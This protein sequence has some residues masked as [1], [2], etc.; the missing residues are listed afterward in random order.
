MQGLYLV[1]TYESRSLLCDPPLYEVHSCIRYF[2]ELPVRFF[3]IFLKQTVIFINQI[4]DIMQVM[5]HFNKETGILLL[6]LECFNAIYCWCCK[7]VFTRIQQF[8]YFSLIKN[9]AFFSVF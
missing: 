3:N 9:I 8:I 7:A 1:N 4:A 5:K 2:T 6:S